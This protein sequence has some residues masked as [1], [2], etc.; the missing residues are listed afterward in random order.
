MYGDTVRVKQRKRQ[1]G[2]APALH[3]PRRDY[4]VWQ[5]HWQLFSAHLHAPLGQPQ[6][7]VLQPQLQFRV[8]VEVF[9]F[10]IFSSPYGASCAS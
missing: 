4:F 5:P 9:V 10:V 7:Q 1:K 8:V 2:G 6:E 3:R